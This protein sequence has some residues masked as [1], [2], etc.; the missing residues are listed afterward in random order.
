MT[1]NDLIDA[2][3]ERDNRYTRRRF[4]GIAY[5]LSDREADVVREHRNR[6]IG[7]LP[8]GQRAKAWAE[9]KAWLPPTVAR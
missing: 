7:L 5:P 8:P 9:L 3:S 1:A 6:E 2:W 4:L